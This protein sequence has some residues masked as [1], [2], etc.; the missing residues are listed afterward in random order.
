[1][2]L[3]VAAFLPTSDQMHKWLYDPR[4]SCTCTIASWPLPTLSFMTFDLR[5]LKHGLLIYGEFGKHSIL[6]AFIPLVNLTP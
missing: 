2:M 1:M 4:G 3:A 5:L 6:T